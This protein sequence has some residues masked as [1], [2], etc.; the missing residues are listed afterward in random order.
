MWLL[1][2]ISYTGIINKLNPNIKIILAGI[3]NCE[4]I[5]NQTVKFKSWFLFLRQ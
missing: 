1:V 2:L 4:D 5:I 3:S